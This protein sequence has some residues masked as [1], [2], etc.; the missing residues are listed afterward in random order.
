MIPSELASHVVA[1]VGGVAGLAIIGFLGQV[2]H[3]WVVRRLLRDIRENTRTRP[4]QN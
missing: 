2:Y 4:I 1:F 3:N